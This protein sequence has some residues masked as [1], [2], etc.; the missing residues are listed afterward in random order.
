[1]ISYVCTDSF[2]KLNLQGSLCCINKPTLRMYVHSSILQYNVTLTIF[3]DI[4]DE[5]LLA[6]S[7]QPTIPPTENENT[8]PFYGIDD[9]SP[10]RTALRSFYEIR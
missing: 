5:S 7:D 1:M 6:L 8:N 2:C 9:A 10:L 4:L 3:D